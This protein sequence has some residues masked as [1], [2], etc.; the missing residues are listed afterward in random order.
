MGKESAWQT[1]QQKPKPAGENTAVLLE[2]QQ[3][4]CVVGT[5]GK[6]M[7]DCQSPGEGLWPLLKVQGQ[8]FTFSIREEK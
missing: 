1:E 8:D 3:H 7:R 4:G 5:T 2:E 6:S